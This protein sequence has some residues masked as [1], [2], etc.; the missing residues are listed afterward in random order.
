ME[1]MISLFSLTSDTEECLRR[2]S[3]HDFWNRSWPNEPKKAKTEPDDYGSFR[4][5]WF[6]DLELFWDLGCFLFC[7]FFRFGSRIEVGLTISV[8]FQFVNCVCPFRRRE[9]SGKTA[10]T[11]WTQ[12]ARSWPRSRR[13]ECR[14]GSGK[15]RRIE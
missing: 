1:V 14:K 13:S 5:F 10:R 9:A 6:W 2:E 7:I 15:R 11:P 12:E 4:D 3:G 8:S